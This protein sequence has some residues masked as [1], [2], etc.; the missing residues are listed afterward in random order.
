M[1]SGKSEALDVQIAAATRFDAPT[2]LQLQKLAYQ[3]EARLYNDWSLPPLTE[4]VTQLQREFDKLTLLKAVLDGVLV[5]AVRASCSKGRC[6]VGR[7]IVRPDLQSKGIG[8][9]L[10]QRIEAEFPAA[11]WFELFTGARSLRNIRFYESLGYRAFRAETVSPKLTL[12]WMEKRKPPMA[13]DP[14]ASLGTDPAS[15]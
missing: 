14:A 12:T 7:L 2:I 10:M 9:A 8:R 11:E 1:S 4:T 5:G 3:S 13:A 15:S 6:T